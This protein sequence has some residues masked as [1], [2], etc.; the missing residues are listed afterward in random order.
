MFSNDLRGYA[1]QAR[2]S[3]GEMTGIPKAR[4]SRGDQDPD[5]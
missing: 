4:V 1:F 2:A 3:Q 5:Q